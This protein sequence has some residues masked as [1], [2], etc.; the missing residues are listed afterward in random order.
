M[1]LHSLESSDSHLF[2]PPVLIGRNI[3][4]LLGLFAEKQGVIEVEKVVIF[5]LF[6]VSLQNGNAVD[7]LF[8]G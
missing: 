6:G 2:L 5:R 8:F 7:A 3:R 1:L 4:R